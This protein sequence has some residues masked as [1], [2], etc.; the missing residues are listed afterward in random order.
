MFALMFYLNKNYL[1]KT[2]FEFTM[3]AYIYNYD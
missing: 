2:L 1:D 3:I